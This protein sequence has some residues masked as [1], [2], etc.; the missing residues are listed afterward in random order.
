MVSAFAFI[1]G[2]SAFVIP[3]GMFPTDVVAWEEMETIDFFLLSLSNSTLFAAGDCVSCDPRLPV[4]DRCVVQL[5]NSHAFITRLAR[6]TRHS[7]R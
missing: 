5:S 3:L 1:L 6:T 2:G 7:K 4:S